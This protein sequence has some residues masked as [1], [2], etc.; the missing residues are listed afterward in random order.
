MFSTD[1]PPTSADMSRLQAFRAEGVAGAEL[2]TDS[3]LQSLMKRRGS[4]VVELLALYSSPEDA[5][6]AYPDPPPSLLQ[7]DDDASSVGEKASAA[8]ATTGTGGPSGGAIA[9][10]L[11]RARRENASAALGASSSARTAAASAA[12]LASAANGSPT[13]VFVEGVE[14]VNYLGKS[15]LEPPSNVLEHEQSTKQKTC[16]PPRTMRGLFK[17]SEDSQAAVGTAV[18]APTS[19]SSVVGEGVS[20]TG[21]RPSGKASGVQQL[22]WA[23]PAYGHLLFSGDIGGECRLWNSSTRQL[24]ATFAAHT[25]PI[26][27][28]EVT[29]NAAIM[30]TGS[31][32]G[33]VAMW[34]VESGICAHVLTNPDR[35]PV[36]QHLHHPSNEEHLL[37]AAVDKKVVL[38]DV[39]VGC[40][41][42][43]REYTG[44]MGAI[45]NLTLLS[46]GSK[47]LTTSE[48]K[49]L[50]T[51]DYRSP[52]QIKQFADA[53]MHAITHVL[54]HPTQPE[55]LAAQSLNNKVIVFRDD[56][57]GRLRLLHDREFTGHTISGTRCQ[58]SF[59][60][61]GQYLSSG[62]ISGKLYVWDWTTK[63]LEKSF[64]A[65]A[66]M[67]V[68][69]LWHPI[70]P[71]KVVTAAWDGH[72]KSWV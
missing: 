70:E 56:G 31:V 52:V 25:Q 9:Q 71:T 30:S 44:H 50:R 10:A 47:M 51:W 62:D 17:V 37:L 21:E 49:T 40:A 32:D 11:K 20:H 48:D 55:F 39:R 68:S 41:K 66:Q 19:S 69:H 8:A 53:A 23:P 67:L 28:L 22:R 2:P 18:S 5:R 33:T 26:K 58:L 38:Y 1:R 57:G 61:D 14:R 45:F 34:D 13:A 72:I 24:L 4:S 16:K 60:H 36:V 42:Y 3:Y 43:Q 65:H 6:K 35:L 27:S 64:K 59:S 46:D 63:K 15:F 12:R 54:H 29:S 7:V